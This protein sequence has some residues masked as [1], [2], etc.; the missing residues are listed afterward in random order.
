MLRYLSDMPTTQK[1]HSNLTET[2]MATRRK[3]IPNKIDKRKLIETVQANPN[4]SVRQ[5]GTLMDT[6]HSAIV[7]ALQRYGIDKERLEGYKANR[8][9][10]F[11]GL[12]EIVASSLTAGDINNA[13]VRDRTMLMGVL[14]D[15]E[16]LERGQS[17]SNQSVFFQLVNDSDSAGE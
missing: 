8:A 5:L 1:L 11:A 16:R 17:T 15:K 4:L 13:S 14:Y 3:P 7:Q 12:Q 2:G 6:T 9:D 10:V